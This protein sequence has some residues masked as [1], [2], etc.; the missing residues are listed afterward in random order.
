MKKT[1]RED[2]AEDIQR[3]AKGNKVPEEEVSSMM[4]RVRASKKLIE[5]KKDKQ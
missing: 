4:E 5:P 2:V 1:Y 3:R